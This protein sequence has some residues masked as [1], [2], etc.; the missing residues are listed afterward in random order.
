[1][2]HDLGVSYLFITHNFGV[3]EYL[4]AALFIV[5]GVLA[6]LF[7]LTKMLRPPACAAMHQLASGLLQSPP[8]PDATSVMASFAKARG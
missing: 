3:V 6:V 2:Q 8:R 5:L 4:A 1:M 7:G